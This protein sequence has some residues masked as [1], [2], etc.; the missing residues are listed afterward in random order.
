MSFI[1]HFLVR[2]FFKKRGFID[3][4]DGIKKKHKNDIPLS[5][6]L[7]FAVSFMIFSIFSFDVFYFKL[8]SL[9]SPSLLEVVLIPDNYPYVSLTWL[10]ILSMVL[11]AICLIDDLINL[12]VWVRLFAQ[13]SCTVLMIEVGGMNLLNLGPLFGFE[14]IVLSYYLGFLFTIFCVVGITNA[15]NWIDGIDGFFSFQVI[16]ACIGISILSNRF[17]LALMAFLCALVHYQIMNLGLM[18]EK[19]TV[20]IGDQ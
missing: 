6:G 13:I 11:L 16:L 15:F 14:D 9:F 5:G 17:S 10:I 8:D 1:I 19:F 3:S 12:P 7:Y 2:D 18:V 4:P 20:L